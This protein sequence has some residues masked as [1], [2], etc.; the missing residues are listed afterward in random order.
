[1]AI[2]QKM[3]MR[4]GQGLVMTPQLQQA[5]KLLQLSSLELNAYV[6]QELERNPILERVEDEDFGEQPIEATDKSDDGP[7]ELCISADAPDPNAE[8]AI[9]ASY[10]DMNNDADMPAADTIGMTTDWS[11][12]GEG[13]AYDDLEGI[14]NSLATK[15]SL[16]DHLQTQ[17]NLSF[18]TPQ[19]RMI[20]AYLI[21]FVDDGGYLRADMV[22]T[23][24]NLGTSLE[25]IEDVVKVL[26]TFD[27]VGVCAR[28]VAECL[29][30]QLKEKDRFDPAMEKLVAN[31]DLLAKRDLRTLCT[32]CEV[33]GEDI[34]QMIG[35]IRALTPKP[36][37]TFG[38]SEISAI[39]PDVFVREAPNGMWIVELNSDTLPRVLVNN[40]YCEMV[41]RTART[42]DEKSF[43]TSAQAE[44][45]WLVKS[46]D[47][48][49]K[50]IL[51]VAREIVRQQDGFLTYGL[52][53]LRPL[54]LK[55]VATVI[56]M[57]ES[58][59]SRVTANKFISTPRGI[60]ELK[61]FFTTAIASIY[62]G[63]TH[64]SE[65]VRH[66]IKHLIDEE[67]NL[68]PLSDDAIVEILKQT[69]IDIARRTVAKYREALRIPS[70]VQ[71]RRDGQMA[72]G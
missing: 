56:E 70:S 15:I 51:K 1:M 60:F 12:A 23:A 11:K 32:I 42:D 17:A 50:T 14:E 39:T 40:A 62:G 9:D 16:H 20:A 5:I 29:A 47:Q 71:R 48:R 13:R 58:T 18:D 21:D 49:A 33:D 45:S 41:S 31:L 64:S 44:A 36:G 67:E 7:Q 55:D 66:Q 8:S 65:K 61:Y 24:Q 30:L 52:S 63:E 57:H 68:A 22:E 34:A 38:S 26:Q 69:G 37:A 72:S 4:Q 25:E 43:I 53:H 35:E 10:E 28:N 54:V 59:V 6:E 27:P 46:L 2:G 19:S 3:E